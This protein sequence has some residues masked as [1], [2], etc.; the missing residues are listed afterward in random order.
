MVFTVNNNRYTDRTTKLY[1]PPPPKKICFLGGSYI[2]IPIGT[3]NIFFKRKVSM[4][5]KLICE[6]KLSNLVLVRIL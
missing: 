5:K 2:G 1:D 6:K 3:R 4:N